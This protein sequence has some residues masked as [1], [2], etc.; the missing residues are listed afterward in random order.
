M[1][2]AAKIGKLEVLKGGEEVLK[3]DKPMMMVEIHTELLKRYK[4]TEIDV[5]QFLI[6]LG[7]GFIQINHDSR[8]GHYLFVH[9]DKL[10]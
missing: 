4:S 2:E 3:R 10:L 5:M 7:Y 9:K 8:L 1:I 6:S